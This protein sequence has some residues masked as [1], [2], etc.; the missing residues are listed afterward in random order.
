[1]TSARLTS[2]TSAQKLARRIRTTFK[3]AHPT[4]DAQGAS[5]TIEGR[6]ASNRT[7]A[8]GI[9]GTRS[10][11][12]LVAFGR[13]RT[14]RTDVAINLATLACYHRKHDEA[15]RQQGMAH[16]PMRYISSKIMHDHANVTRCCI[17]CEFFYVSTPATLA[18]MSACA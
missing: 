17:A 8:V 16:Q 18:A 2:P 4:L 11:A 14:A 10:E 9:R 6:R 15:V 5:R 1:M 13:R 7:K 12:L 3:H